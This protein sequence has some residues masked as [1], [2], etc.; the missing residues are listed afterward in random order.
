MDEAIRVVEE[1]QEQ[2]IELKR[3]LTN[4]TDLD[5]LHWISAQIVAYGVVR[6]RL[7]SYK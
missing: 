4:T 5:E 3:K 6:G 2:A 1:L 7:E